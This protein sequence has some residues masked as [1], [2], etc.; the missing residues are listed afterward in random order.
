MLL[1]L[2]V[3]RAV[4]DIVIVIVSIFSIIQWECILFLLLLVI[5]DNIVNFWQKLQKQVPNENQQYWGK[6]G[7]LSEQQRGEIVLSNKEVLL[8][9]KMK[10][11]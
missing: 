1:L 11:R 7:Q 8:L 2:L 9:L 5:I 10:H 3:K 4:S 6:S